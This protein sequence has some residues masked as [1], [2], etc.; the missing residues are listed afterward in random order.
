MSKTSLVIFLCL[1]ALVGLAKCDPTATTT[2]ATDT[3]TTTYEPHK[4]GYI[5]GNNVP[6]L[7]PGCEYK[8]KCKVKLQNAEIPKPCLKTCVESWIC[9]KQKKTIRKG[10]YC[11]EFNEELVAEEYK[12]E[13]EAQHVKASPVAM[14]DFPCQ[15]GYLPDSRG[16]CREV[17]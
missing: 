15:P 5:I 6:H 8:F 11:V 14:I 12:A 9:N 7:E 13:K 4:R 17:W 3:E 16:R 1:A 2:S 10:F